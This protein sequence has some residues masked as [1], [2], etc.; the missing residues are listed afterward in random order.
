MDS[1]WRREAKSGG[2]SRI[3]ESLTKSTKKSTYKQ[4]QNGEVICISIIGINLIC[5]IWFSLV[6]LC[7]FL[8][9]DL[10]DFFHHA[11]RGLFTGALDAK[12]SQT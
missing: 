11:V 3:S 6:F 8:F 2:R 4:K 5:F 10:N 12:Q 1:P 9:V 7:N